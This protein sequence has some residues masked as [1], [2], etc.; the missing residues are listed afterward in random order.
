MRF[1][2][3]RLDSLRNLQVANWDVAFATA[4]ATLVTGNFL[5]GY[6]DY[7]GGGDYW[8]GLITAVPSF[9][10]LV[11]VPGAIWG[12]SFPF[13]K[14]FIAPGGWVWRL[15]YIPLV[16]LPFM[17]LPGEAKLSLLLLCIGVAA[18]AIQAVN[19]IYNDWLAKLVPSTSRGW[20]FSRRTLVAT[21]VGMVAGLAGGLALDAFRDVGQEGTGF[22][23]VFG[24]G[25]VCAMV[26]MVFF[27]R[28]RE[29]VRED[30]VRVSMR[31]SVRSMARPWQDKNFRLLLIFSGLFMASQTYAGGFFSLF[32]IK[33][34]EI[35]F[36]L[37]QLIAVMHALGTIAFV[38]TWGYLAD[39]YGNKPILVLTTIGT[40]ITPGVWLVCVPGADLRNAVILLVFHIYNG[41]VWSGVTVTQLNL[42]MSTAEERDRSSYLGAALTTTAVI[43][44]LAPIL[45]SMT[46]DLLRGPLGAEMAFKTLFVIVIGMRVVSVFLLTGV[47]EEGAVSIR[48]TIRQMRQVSLSGMRARSALS[49][50]ADAERRLLAIK[51][52]GRKKFSMATAELRKALTDPSPR[53]RRGAALALAQLGGDEA[54]DALITHIIEHPELLDEDVVE[55]LSRLP[56]ERTEPILLELLKDPRSILRRSAA[57]TLGRLGSRAAVPHLILAAQEMDDIEMRRAALQA[58]RHL[59]AREAEP[60]IADALLDTH[61]SVRIAA[62]EAVSELHLVRTAERVRAALLQTEDEALPEVAYALGCVGSASDV[63]LIVA[64]AR[65]CH[66]PTTRRRCLLGIARLLGVEQ[67]AYRLLILDGFERDTRMLEA[68]KD[69][70]RSDT[71]LRESLDRYSSGDEGGAIALL[72]ANCG[73]P[74]LWSLADQPVEESFIVAWLACVARS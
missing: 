9:I 23:V 20:Y 30:P 18:A 73:I 25:V 15:L 31:E 62:A 36:T 61:P 27:L 46:M 50:S 64:A 65:K 42:Y 34:L 56:S 10:G 13:Y 69:V 5:I 49:S 16:F 4:F 57:K 24:A 21:A 29:T 44:G 22:S 48:Q 1:T 58:L 41:V 70:R 26:S 12:R 45:G 33:V 59:E 60:V 47:R 40:V 72:A 35:N 37:L 2:E 17:P 6:I 53:I 39:K 11:Q 38:R 14:K 28:M 52:V 7:F 19:P 55:A 8:I 68:L 67:P 3:N 54:A 66:S 74:E 43:G 51:V 63:P 71:V 32:A